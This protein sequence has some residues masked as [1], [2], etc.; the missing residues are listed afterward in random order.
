MLAYLGAAK[1]A[2]TH[3]LFTPFL[4]STLRN[5]VCRARIEELVPPLLEGKL[6]AVITFIIIPLDKKDNNQKR[7]EIQGKF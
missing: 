3:S 1:S 4:K 7:G 2:C 6:R 5:N